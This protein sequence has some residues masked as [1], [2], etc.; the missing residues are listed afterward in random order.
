MNPAKSK[1]FIVGVLCLFLAVA[2]SCGNKKDEKKENKTETPK[3][4]TGNTKP[5]VPANAAPGG[6]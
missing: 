5:V 1:L 4:D 3:M 2:T 6:Q